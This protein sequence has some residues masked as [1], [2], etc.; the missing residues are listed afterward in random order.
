MNATK[1]SYLGLLLLKT[2]TAAVLAALIGLLACEG[3]E[4]PN[5]LG[6]SPAWI[7]E[8][9]L[10]AMLCCCTYHVYIYRR[11]LPEQCAHIRFVP[12][13]GQLLQMGQRQAA[14][15]MHIPAVAI[16]ILTVA[17]HITAVAMHLPAVAM[18]ITAVA[19]HIPA[20]AMHLPALMMS[21]VLLLP[22]GTA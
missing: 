20:V 9:G 12:A 7:M 17:M 2:R 11:S 3:A 14:V 15:A 18:H 4:A 8:T 13:Q 1:R 22:V 5:A 21:L 10:L 19:M 16:H 6:L